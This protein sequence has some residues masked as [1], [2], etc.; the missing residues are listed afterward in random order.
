[1][2]ISAEKMI[3][4]GKAQGLFSK[5]FGTFIPYKLAIKVGIIKIMEMEASCFMTTFRLFEMTDA[6][7][8]IIPLWM[9]E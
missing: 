2:A 8:S 4:I 1:M 9:S 7:A 6:N 5:W 3:T